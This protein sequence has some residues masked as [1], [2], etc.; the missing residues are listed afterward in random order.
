MSVLYRLA[1]L[2][3]NL[4]R[5]ARVEREMDTE[6]EGFVRMLAD[7]KER[8]GMSPVDARRA[9]LVEVGGV[10]Q[11]KEEARSARAGA[12]I[13]TIARD[14]RFGVRMALKHPVL[15][16]SVVLTFGLG[17]GL[18]T[19]VFG[20]IEGLFLK[21]LP[22]EGADR[23]VALGHFD[24]QQ[25]GR[26]V[27]SLNVRDFLDLRERQTVLEGL[28]AYYGSR[29]NVSLDGGEPERYLA[30]F[31]TAG[32]FEQLNVR[33]ALGRTFRR[34]EDTPGAD[35][36]VI[37]GYD[38][39]RERFGGSGDVLGRPLRVHGT[40]RTIVGVMPQGFAFPG[41]ERLYVPLQLD[42]FA[43]WKA[44]GPS[45]Q[46]IG[47]LPEGRA[48]REAQTELATLASRLE[49]RGAGS[50]RAPAITGLPFMASQRQ[51]GAPAAVFAMLAAALGVLLIAAS[52]VTNLLLARASARSRE[53]AVRTALGATRW[54]VVLQLVVEV[55]VL[56]GAGA[57]VGLGLAA[58]GL[59]W[60]SSA[61]AAGEEDV[62]AWISFGLDGRVFWFAAFVTLLA[63]LASS[64]VP[65]LRT[66]S[67]DP[68]SVLKDGSG[69][70][71]GLRMG[72]LSSALIMGEV[73][74]S[75]VLLIACGLMVRSVVRLGTVDLPFATRS[76]FT[77]SLT[78][79]RLD[80]LDEG[81]RAA[82]YERLQARLEA[83]PGVEAAALSFSLP[84]S[85]SSE[86]PVEIEGRPYSRP[87]DY[88]RA[89]EAVAGPRYFETFG[90]AVARGRQFEVSD[91]RGALPVAVVNE[92]FVRRHFPDGQAI[93][94]RFRPG[95]GDTTAA[96][97]TVVGVV[98]D[99]LM[100]GFEELTEDPAGYYTP[101]AQRA[102]SGTV[103]LAL[104]VRGDPMARTSDV[105]AA[106][107]SLDPNLP[108]SDVR[109]MDSHV[110]RRTW[111]FRDF[112]AVFVTFGLSALLLASMGLYGVISFS[113]A[114]R[115]R[116]MGVR[117]ALGAVGSQLVWLV[118]RKGAALLAI[119]LAIGLALAVP[120]AGTLSVFLFQVEPRDPLVFGAVVAT[121]VGVGLLAAYVPARRVT[122]VNPVVA[123]SAE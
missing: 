115:A 23:I 48:V 57:V 122:K 92:R 46:V 97:L 14:V 105:R 81:A 108:L 60:F 37:L 95:R 69:G 20:F 111:F 99:L 8:S 6:L 82:F 50:E 27:R 3:R 98:P 4:F 120:T 94:R 85:T 66:A 15:S 54:R 45:Y 59:A 41:R 88:T 31:Y 16:L 106:V 40:V 12:L 116:E 72:R 110:R 19:A 109:S 79:P 90:V 22:F 1:S 42:P 34:G 24:A 55:L 29:V 25:G 33:P 62:K 18:T 107:R 32:T 101:I 86:G 2:F 113:V 80:Y 5:R 30:G 67:A 17:I 103:C 39:W 114:R 52:N 75:C 104:R 35:P 76:I 119:G 96:W 9:A 7:E 102:W 28:A 47:R 112:G 36:V 26:F 123:L 121:L 89:Q 51:R 117:M 71:S 68:I 77:A 10:E 61:L 78:L 56:A 43:P 58:S 11:V 53:V 100:Q 38:L 91:R 84:G 49:R 73:A 65:A 118:L 21:G 63:G 87:S 83:I 74:V 93:G 70:S 64:L 13:E 44:N